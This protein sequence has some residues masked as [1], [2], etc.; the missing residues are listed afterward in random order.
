M[1]KTWDFISSVEGEAVGRSCARSSTTLCFERLILANELIKIEKPKTGDQ[2]R[3]HCL[4][5]T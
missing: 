5:Y 3:D 4:L 2:V 1:R